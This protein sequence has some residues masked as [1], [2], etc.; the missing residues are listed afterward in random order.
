MIVLGKSP[1]IIVVF[2]NVQFTTILLVLL[3]ITYYSGITRLKILW[4][5]GRAIVSIKT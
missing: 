3:V 1:C 2:A 4:G 5:R